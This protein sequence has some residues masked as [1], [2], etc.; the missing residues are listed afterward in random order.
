MTE[1]P[2]NAGL[3]HAAFLG[4]A[5]PFE[6]WNSFGSGCSTFR[7]LALGVDF[8]FFVFVHFFDSRILVGHAG[9][10]SR[11]GWRAGVRSGSLPRQRLRRSRCCGAEWRIRLGG[12]VLNVPNKDARDQSRERRYFCVDLAPPLEEQNVRTRLRFQ[13]AC[14]SAASGCVCRS[15]RRWR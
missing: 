8:L 9:R 11:C 2:R 4:K 3:F 10:L 12:R 14:R 15:Q 1:A 6:R 7:L 13:V 5:R